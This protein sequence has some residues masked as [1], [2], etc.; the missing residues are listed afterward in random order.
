VIYYCPLRP[1][2]FRT[3]STPDDSFWCCVG[4]G[5]ENH[6][7][8]PDTIYFR[9]A[10]SLYVNLFIPSELTWKEKG[11]TVRQET[12]F[13]EEDT[14]KLTFTGAKPVRLALKVRYPAWA[15]QGMT[16]AVNGRPEKSVAKPGS[17]VTVQR[18]WRSGDT[19][20]IRLPMSLRLETLPGDA[21][22]VAVFYGPV[23]LA[24]ISARTASRTRAATA[25]ARRR[26]AGSRRRS[27]RPSSSN[28]RT[29]WR[30]SRRPVHRS[31][32]RPQASA[33][34][35]TRRSCRSAGVRRALHGVL[36]HLHAGRMGEAR[37]GARGDG[38]AP[39]RGG[40]PDARHRGVR[41]REAEKTHAF[42]GETTTQ[43]YFEGR[44][45]RETRTGWFSY[46][47][48]VAPDKPV[49]LVCTYRGGEGRR[50]VFDIL[51]DGQKIATETLAYHPTELLDV[52]YAI[53][54][55]LTK[56]KPRVTIRF[57]PQKDASTATVLEIRT[58]TGGR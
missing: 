13:P 3:Y 23:L 42:H 19:V 4:T 48:A 35:E 49:T 39:E 18:E 38:G 2:A 11:L 29:S 45:G 5:L 33:G 44:R 16:V 6:A 26:S 15:Q 54:E 53:P 20:L 51:V 12:R 47:L 40:E 22:M 28:A 41:Q 1:G 14:T 32:S 10:A 56:G 57:Q 37:G 50:R 9:D 46:E 27:C 36:E 30:A 34:R 58:I 24:A 43:P 31:R 25:P 55:A 21:S 8:Y 7:K 17:Y 52:E